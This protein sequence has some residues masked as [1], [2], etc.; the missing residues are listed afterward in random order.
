MD[1]SSVGRFIEPASHTEA[2]R[3]LY[4]LVSPITGFLRDVCRGHED[5]GLDGK[6]VTPFNDLYREYS[7]WC[8]EN[9]RKPKNA[10]GFCPTSRRR[11]PASTDHRPWTEPDANGERKRMP[12]QVVGLA[13]SP[14][15]TTRVRTFGHWS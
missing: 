7:T 8:M 4:D 14:E 9:G 10:S 6:I 2:M 3:E 1:L 13:I 5:G 15:W 12:R 11:S